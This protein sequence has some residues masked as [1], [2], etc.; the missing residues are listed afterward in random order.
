MPG[1][2]PP[3]RAAIAA[4]AAV[5][6]VAGSLLVWT[7]LFGPAS[8]PPVPDSGTARAEGRPTEQV[9]ERRPRASPH[10]TPARADRGAADLIKGPTLPESKPVRVEIP[11]LGV[12]SALV[13]LGVDATGAM[14]VPPDPAVAGWYVLG[15]TPGAL[16]P[17][18][19]AGHV[20]WNRVPAI[21]FRLATMRRGDRVTVVRKDGIK[22]VFSVTR[23]ARFDKTSFPTRAVFGSIDH[24]GLRLI[25]CGGRYDVTDHRYLANVV[26]FATL[27]AAHPSG[28]AGR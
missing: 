23:V 2:R 13:G 28:A 22:A 10:A 8:P 7:A 21:F 25:T 27:V 5:L 11:R 3:V 16:G 26:V 19:I 17:A 24:A 6:G 20:T 1:S 14:D 12:T 9:P 4:L 18:V 15:P